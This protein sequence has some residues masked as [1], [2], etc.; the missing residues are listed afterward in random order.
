[1]RTDSLSFDTANGVTTAYV[2]IPDSDT[3]RAV[4]VVQEYWGLKDHI[5]DI[6]NRWAGEGFI[7]RTRSLSRQDRRHRRGSRQADAG[8]QDRRRHRHH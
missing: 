7:D 1:M 3:N 5:K 2:A 4:I 8:A 6:A